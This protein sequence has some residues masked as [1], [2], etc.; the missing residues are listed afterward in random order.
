MSELVQQVVILAGGL[1]TRLA[2]RTKLRPKPLMPV[3]GKPYLEWQIELLKE[4]GFRDLLLLTGYLA[5]QIENH[6]RDGSQWH[7]RIAYSRE[8]KSLGTAAALKLARPKLQEKFLVMNGD[9]FFPFDYSAFI[10]RAVERDDCVW[11]VVVPGRCLAPNAPRGN[12]CLDVD[13]ERVVRYVRGGRDD[14]DFVHAGMFV[15]ARS[16][17]SLMG[18]EEGLALEAALYPPLI[19]LGLLRAFVCQERFFDMGTPQQ[20]DELEAFLSRKK[21]RERQQNSN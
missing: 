20:L 7:V 11:M 5:E 15:L 1:G 17:L 18:S 19:E 4:S 21:A 12:V 14:L 3:A 13:G 9:T 6:F 8:L 16:Q 2:E 10:R